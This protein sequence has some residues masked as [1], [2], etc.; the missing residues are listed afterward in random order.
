MNYLKTC[1]K[2]GNLKLIKYFFFKDEA[3]KSAKNWRSKREHQHM[4]FLKEKFI[5]F[6][7]NVFPQF[8][9]LLKIKGCFKSMYFVFLKLVTVIYNKSKIKI[10]CRTL[11]VVSQKFLKLKPIK[12]QKE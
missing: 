7:C 8:I 1:I 12:L 2:S 10:A 9:F 4:S 6:L 5:V 3:P 11:P